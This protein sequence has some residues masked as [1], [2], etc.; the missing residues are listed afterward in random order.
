MA[1]VTRYD[2]RH[3]GA[4]GSAPCSEQEGFTCG[5]A[6]FHSWP[7]FWRVGGG[8]A[9]ALSGQGT[10]PAKAAGTVRTVDIV[11][12]GERCPRREQ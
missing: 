6:R 10:G 11:G 5:L 12:T 1:A 3:P 8:A 7:R 2:R 4:A 9:A